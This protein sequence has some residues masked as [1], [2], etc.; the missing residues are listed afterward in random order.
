MPCCAPIPL[1]AFPA[2]YFV[3]CLQIKMA[4]EFVKGRPLG[5]SI[6]NFSVRICRPK[7]NNPRDG[8][9]KP[10]VSKATV[11]KVDEGLFVVK[12]AVVVGLENVE[13]KCTL[14]SI[15]SPAESETLHIPVFFLSIRIGQCPRRELDWRQPSSRYCPSKSRCRDT[16]QA[17]H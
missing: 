6:H 4:K 1:R 9:D 13:P 5:A 14:Q 15:V 16:R 2:V 17:A 12:V 3:Q 10:F 8:V 11:N 7:C